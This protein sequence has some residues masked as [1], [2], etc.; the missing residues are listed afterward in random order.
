[1]SSESR[2]ECGL[3]GGKDWWC[4]LSPG[5]SYGCAP[6]VDGTNQSTQSRMDDFAPVKVE[7]VDSER[8]ERYAAAISNTCEYFED[9][10]PGVAADAA[11]AVADEE[12]SAVRAEFEDLRTEMGKDLASQRETIARLRAEL[13]KTTD[14]WRK[15]ALKEGQAHT[16]NVKLRATIERVRA[17]MD[18]MGDDE[19]A[20]TIVYYVRDAIGDN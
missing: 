14:E 7:P 16:E 3:S 6:R 10:D 9:L 4:L 18:D 20:T 1:M 19:S 13:E 2:V 15:T 8:R 5:H 12:I 17:V 11:M